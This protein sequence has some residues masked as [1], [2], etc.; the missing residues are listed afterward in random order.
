MAPTPTS[1]D[2]LETVDTRNHEISRTPQARHRCAGGRANCGQLRWS[3]APGQLSGGQS[4]SVERLLRLARSSRAHCYGL[5]QPT[6]PPDADPHIR[7][8][9]RGEWVT[10]P[11]MPISI[12]LARIFFS[13]ENEC[14]EFP[15]TQ[16]SDKTSQIL[17]HRVASSFFSCRVGCAGLRNLSQNREPGRDF[18]AH[19][20]RRNSER[21]V[22]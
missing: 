18:A 4:R 14:N 5:A 1:V 10:T 12:L 3:V 22:E 7:W 15:R 13:L 11:P 9:G 6:E 19:V 20:F 21:K 16:I 17:L 8:C 2:G